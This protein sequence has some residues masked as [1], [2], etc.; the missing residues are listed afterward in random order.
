MTFERPRKRF[1]QHFLH[2]PAVIDRILNAFDPRPDQAIVEIGPGRGALTLPLLQRVP[3]LHAIE[4]DRDLAARLPALAGNNGGLRLH[5]ADALD[6]DFS[7][8]AP[9][10]RLRLIGNLPYNVATPILFRLIEQIDVVDDMVFMLQKEV[11]DRMAAG[12]GGK[13][14]GRLSVMVQWRCHVEHLF[15]VGPGAFNPPPKVH[16]SV[17]YLRPR[18]PAE[19]IETNPANFAR[20]VQAAF[21]QRRKTLRNSLRGLIDD[22]AFASIGVDPTRRA[23]TLTLDEFAQLAARVARDTG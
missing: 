17:V 8:L 22:A 3:T 9:G 1:G 2:D 7:T 18:A 20:L 19:R 21:A 6:F 16:S 12:P 4:L 15:D 23:E 11:V 13:Q 14:Y 5:Q 10:R